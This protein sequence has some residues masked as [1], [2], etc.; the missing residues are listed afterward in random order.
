MFLINGHIAYKVGSPCCAVEKAHRFLSKSGWDDHAIDAYLALVQHGAQT[1]A[2]LNGFLPKTLNNT[3]LSATLRRL[4]V[5]GA[6]VQAKSGQK[7]AGRRYQATEPTAL[8]TRLQEE[9]K[10]LSR[11]AAD[12]LSP[13]YER[14]MKEGE[15]LHAW[16]VYSATGCHRMLQTH[17][18]AARTRALVH[19][20]AP[21]WLKP[22]QLR[23]IA[24]RLS[25]IDV[26][27]VVGQNSSL[28]G[29]LTATGIPFRAAANDGLRLLVAD[30]R[31]LVLSEDGR[32]LNSSMDAAV[33]N[34]FAEIIASRFAEADE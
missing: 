2:D 19:D 12:E 1:R 8:F 29:S 5:T 31:V 24:G 21:T 22:T 32:H 14:A 13:L 25:E 4:E 28:T 16:S 3:T 10:A 7:N 26:K 20:R 11:T 17:I 34:H 9:S 23:K 15:P 6:L 30:D 27:V 33:V 18:E